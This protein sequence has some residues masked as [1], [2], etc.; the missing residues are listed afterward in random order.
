[1][2]SKTIWLREATIADVPIILGFIQELADYEKL[3][4]AAQA[5][6]DDIER[7]VF[8]ERAYASAIIGELDGVARGMSLYFFNYSTWLGKPGLYL[9][10]LYVQPDARGSGLGKALL[11]NLVRIARE[12]GCGRMEWSVLDWNTPAIEFYESL[13]A[14]PMDGWTTYRLDDAAMQALV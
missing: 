6:A 7:T 9:E 11:L 4:D 3:P 13:G 8:G 14:V 10:D 1:M 12:Q 2:T 5:T